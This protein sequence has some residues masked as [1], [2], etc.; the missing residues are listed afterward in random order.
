[1]SMGH[2]KTEN[3]EWNPEIIFEMYKKRKTE[4]DKIKRE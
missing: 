4:L 1:M 3:D 2:G